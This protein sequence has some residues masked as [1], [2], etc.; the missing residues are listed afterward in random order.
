MNKEEAYSQDRLLSIDSQLED[1]DF[2]LEKY[3]ENYNLKQIC[4]FLDE[5]GTENA[6]NTTSDVS[7]D[8]KTKTLNAKNT[9]QRNSEIY[10]KQDYFQFIE[11]CNQLW[12]VNGLMN[13]LA[14]QTQFE[15]KIHAYS[16]LKNKIDEIRKEIEPLSEVG[17]IGVL[18]NIDD[19]LSQSRLN[20]VNLAEKK[21]E[22]FLQIHDN[23]DVQYTH[24][25]DDL[26]FPTFLKCC[27]N[28]STSDS[29]N[30]FNFNK[31][32]NDWLQKFLSKLDEGFSASFR[33]N[34]G[35]LALTLAETET[36]LL[37]FTKSV[38]QLILFFNGLLIQNQNLIELKNVRIILGKTALKS[39]KLKIFSKQNVYPLIIDK[40]NYD[41]H[42]S[43]KDSKVSTIA[44]LYHVSKLLSSPGWSKDGICELEFW[45][46]DLTSSWI[47]NLIDF[48][49]DELKAFTISLINKEKIDL[50]QEKNLVCEELHTLAN[51]P[52]NSA[53]GKGE[54]D[55]KSTEDDWGDDW[56][57][58]DGWNDVDDEESDDGNLTSERNPTTSGSK[59]TAR[60][61]DEDSDE[62]WGDNDLELDLDL[63]S[64]KDV[65][66]EGEGGG[67]DEDG[68]GAW[69]DELKID[70]DDEDKSVEA[71]ATEQP[72]I[73]SYKYSKIVHEV[74]LIF[75]NYMKNY[76][77]LKEVE[78]SKDQSD[79]AK[80]LF[81]HGF[82]K[83]CVSYFVILENNLTET[84]QNDILFY[85]D[86]NKILEECYKHYDVD[87]TTCFKLGSRF[88]N[89][90]KANIYAKLLS[91]I[92]DYNKVI[93]SD[94]N[95][96]DDI[97]LRA[98]AKEFLTRFDTEFDTVNRRL[99]K[100]VSFNTQ[101]I[102]NVFVTVI[103]QYFNSLCD[104]V[105]ARTDISSYESEILTGI[106]DAIVTNTINKTK[107]LKLMVEKI[108]SYNKL[109]QIKLILSSNLKQI[110][111]AFYDARL[112]EMETHELIS[113]IQSL[114]IES[115]QRTEAI[116][117]VRSVRNA[118]S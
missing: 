93:W 21:L 77:S 68:W 51:T 84:Y 101:L 113:L 24:I 59:I 42:A 99:C 111:E 103:F 78:V 5:I 1:I 98:N 58:N 97:K 69:E 82:K 13:E 83:L 110:L 20:L 106:I 44:E 4:Q 70:G 116:M 52:E 48:T 86:Y 72:L 64:K 92:E 23:L 90:F 117:E 25:I 2:N 11:I 36:S 9:K 95:L 37:N 26:D 89:S 71:Y 109:Q 118:Q 75:D 74:I 14:H 43:Q 17:S 47:D 108:Q 76:E 87:L 10:R 38:G 40:L 53:G 67:E 96:D 60:I 45:I 100:M 63:G 55:K 39:L 114:F 79:E 30:L 8:E 80:D 61:E 94:N 57:N 102:K 35:T 65:A 7:L 29:N 31:L 54:I 3:L 32:F 41:E 22:I 112:F 56:G 107:N 33:E 81:K 27:H 88:I 19:K 50:L 18:D 15:G 16:K 66:I 73:P 62:G 49:I 28:L 12:I 115:P 104:K 34:E 85:N 46:D 105:L 91:V 6:A